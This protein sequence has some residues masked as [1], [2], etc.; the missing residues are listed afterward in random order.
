MHLNRVRITVHNSDKRFQ[1]RTQPADSCAQR[2][3]ITSILIAENIR[4]FVLDFGDN[5]QRGCVAAVAAF[6]FRDSGTRKQI[7]IK[8]ARPFSEH[9]VGEHFRVHDNK[10]MF[11]KRPLAHLRC[12]QAVGVCGA[13]NFC[14]CLS[15]SV[16]SLRARSM[17]RI[18]FNR[19]SNRS[20]GY[21]VSLSEIALSGLRRV[22]M[23]KPL[24]L[25]AAADPGRINPSAGFWRASASKDAL[26]ALAPKN[27]CGRLARL[28]R[29]AVFVA[30]SVGAR[31][32]FRRFEKSP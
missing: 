8:Q 20:S 32:L 18:D 21:C 17:R 10:I 23:K 24:A 14:H 29:F 16:F 28:A 31:F 12:R 19:R 13:E 22:P 27:L 3:A 11:V 26:P 25:A 9:G 7:D 4:H 30:G 1:F 2:F 6:D 15:G 5:A